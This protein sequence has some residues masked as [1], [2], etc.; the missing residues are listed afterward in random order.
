MRHAAVSWSI[1]ALVFGALAGPFWAQDGF[2]LSSPAFT[3][4]ATLPADLK[5]TRDGGDGLTGLC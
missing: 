3:D 1:A 5:C 2:A 4:D